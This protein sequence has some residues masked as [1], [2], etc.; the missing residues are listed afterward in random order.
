LLPKK[1]TIL[2]A[3]NT[4]INCF[5]ILLAASPVI[6]LP[7]ERWFQIEISIFSNESPVDKSEELW[8]PAR[9]QLAF[10]VKMRKLDNLIDILMLDSFNSINQTGI[11][12]RETVVASRELSPE[13]REKIILTTGPQNQTVNYEF[14]FFDFS[15]DDFL[16]L[17]PSS[18]DFQQTNQELERSPAHR[19]LFHGLWRQVV[20]NSALA[21][22]IYVEGGLAYGAQHELQGSLTIRFNEGQDRIVVDANLWFSEFS[23][24]ENLTEKWELPN[25]PEPISYFG[26][27]ETSNPDLIFHP[28]KVYHM[29]QTRD[30]RSREFHYLDHP[31]LGLVISVEPYEL[32]N[33]ISNNSNL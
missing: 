29:Q 1:P 17:P 5:G 10:P 20:T 25:P 14:R 33:P 15:R 8:Q 13:Q 4:L 6:A 26:D 28:T 21:E 31:A 18:S 2:T 24:V 12:D 7:Q 27:P 32:P 19:L 16:Q 30:M 22:P 11:V 23:V 3:K 9:Q